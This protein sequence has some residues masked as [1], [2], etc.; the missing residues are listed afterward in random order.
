MYMH[1]VLFS[2][3]QILFVVLRRAAILTVGTS[4]LSRAPL[5][6]RSLDSPLACR[7]DNFLFSLYGSN[8]PAGLSYTVTTQCSLQLP[9]GTVQSSQTPT[10]GLE[11]TNSLANLG[12]G[13]A[14]AYVSPT[15]LGLV[16][17]DVTEH[18]FFNASFAGL[19]W[20]VSGTFTLVPVTPTLVIPYPKA[21]GYWRVRRVAP[22]L[23]GLKGASYL[24]SPPPPAALA[25]R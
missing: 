9:T 15:S 14:T 2:H 23:R 5:T 18:C 11:L 21:G 19:Q 8:V 22:L 16:P 7:Q 4:D 24:C 17:S 25:G 6:A 10:L 1:V 13:Q 12:S 3:A 20:A